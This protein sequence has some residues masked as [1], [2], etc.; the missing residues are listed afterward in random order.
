MTKEGF[1]KGFKPFDCL[2]LLG[3]E[4]F[5]QSEA[6][7]FMK[8]GGIDTKKS[9]FIVEAALKTD[10]KAR[11]NLIASMTKGVGG[12]QK[13]IVEKSQKPIAIVVGS[14]DTGINN[15]YIEKEVSKNSLW[16]RKVHVIEAGHAVFWE[17]PEKFNE[18]VGN[19]L[20]DINPNK[21]VTLSLVGVTL[22][23]AAL[24]RWWK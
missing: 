10:G 5:S 14:Q 17:K 6:E 3:Q 21:S 15:D 2:H 19:F 20:E 16:Q 18:L 4:K 13:E 24:F 7:T 1:G 22:A 11:A 9:P 23:V 8:Q 12:N